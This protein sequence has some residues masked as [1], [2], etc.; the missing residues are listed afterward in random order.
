MH[1]FCKDYLNDGDYEL[2]KRSVK[3]AMQHPHEIAANFVLRVLYVL[4][5][6]A[7][8]L[9]ASNVGGRGI[10]TFE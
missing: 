10:L 4:S 9:L 7:H 6:S 5:S 2:L 8:K 3:N 1:A